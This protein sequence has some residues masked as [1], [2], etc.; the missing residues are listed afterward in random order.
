M[1]LDKMLLNRDASRAYETTS[2]YLLMGVE[3]ADGG[4]GLRDMAW[5]RLR[6]DRGRSGVAKGSVEIVA[7]CLGK[8][9]D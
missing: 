5:N 9:R 2:L 7:L 3:E 8:E 1:H 6:G 4:G